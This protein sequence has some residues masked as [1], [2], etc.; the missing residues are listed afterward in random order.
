MSNY[1]FLQV[2]TADSVREVCIRHQYYTKGD[3]L[4]YESMFEMCGYVTPDSLEN[5]AKDI[6][7]HSNTDDSVLDIMKVLAV[8]IHTN[9]IPNGGMCRRASARAKRLSQPLS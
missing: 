3:C 4:A 7:E 9:V 1:N 2:L 5:I 8:H 6:K